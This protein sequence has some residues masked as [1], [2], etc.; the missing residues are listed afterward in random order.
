M[1]FASDNAGPA[2]PAVLEAIARAND[3]HQRAYGSESALDRVR[4][5]IRE[6]FEAPQ[7]EVHL[8]GT[9]TAANS[10]ILGCMAQPWDAIFCSEHAHIEHDEGNAPEF[11]TGGAKLS[12]VPAPDGRMSVADLER[13]IG[14]EGARSF[15]NAQAGPISVTQVTETGAVYGLDQ[16]RAI[17]DLARARGQRVHMD[18]ARFANA[19]AALGCSPAEMT[20]KAGVDA[21]SFGGT[22]NGLLGVE[23]AV[24]FE[25][26]LA[27]DFA[28]RRKRG[29]HLFSKHRFLSAQMEA[30]LADDLWLDLAR[31]ANAAGRMLVEGLRAHEDAEILYPAEANLVFV[32]LPRATLR[33]LI[34]A[35]ADFYVMD[36]DPMAGDPEARLTARMVC[37]WSVGEEGVARFLSLL[38]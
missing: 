26:D 37:D 3:G 10:L 29:G 35:G 34:E 32:T 2:H 25:P 28:L 38:G 36:G 16:L 31:R 8:V 9:G 27:R 12:I 30:Y 18:G 23:A 33:R 11:Y 19:V 13:V 22:K 5:R 24:F 4:D 15:H 1:Q 6:I 20:W 14:P 21:L 7:A 17:G